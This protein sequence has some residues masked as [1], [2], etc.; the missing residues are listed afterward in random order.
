MITYEQTKGADDLRR[1]VEEALSIA[2]LLHDEKGVSPLLRRCLIRLSAD[3]ER[4]QHLNV[5]PSAS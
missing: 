2:E 5:V 4:R 3:F 1:T